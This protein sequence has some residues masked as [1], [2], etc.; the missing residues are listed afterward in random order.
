MCPLFSKYLPDAEI[1]RPAAEDE[2]VNDALD[3]DVAVRTVAVPAGKP[4]WRVVRV[5]HLTPDE[6]RNKHALYVSLIDEQGQPITAASVQLDWG[7][8]WFD[9]ELKPEGV[10]ALVYPLEQG[11]VY[12]ARVQDI[13]SDEVIG[14]HTYHAEEGKGNKPGRHSFAVTWQRQTPSLTVEKTTL[15]PHAQPAAAAKA[16]ST[17]TQLTAMPGEETKREAA[18]D[19]AKEQAE[20]TTPETAVTSPHEKPIPHYVLFGRPFAR[21]VRAHFALAMDYLLH[22]K[23]SFGFNNVDTACLAKRVTIIADEES[24]VPEDEQQLRRE[25]CEVERLDLPP[26]ELLRVLQQRME[27]EQPFAG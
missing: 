22:F 27:E 6:N 25:G 26:A 21:G 24:F 4:V 7:T 17:F 12:R 13:L 10:F 20:M 15:L 9:I 1:I 18:P 2:V 19:H 5:H 16:L 23:L 11:V 8:G 14:L 3:Y